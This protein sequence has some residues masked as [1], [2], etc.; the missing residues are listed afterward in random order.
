MLTYAYT[1]NGKY[2]LG[3]VFVLFSLFS[4]SGA[5]LL[6]GAGVTSA[7]S[8]LAAVVAAARGGVW[9]IYFY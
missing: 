5:S 2:I 4:P 9:E 3:P 1:Q 8:P 6:C 7:V